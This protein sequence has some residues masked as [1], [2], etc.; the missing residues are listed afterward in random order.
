MPVIGRKRIIYYSVVFGALVAWFGWRALH[1][2]AI[3]IR[4][5]RTGEVEVNG[6]ATDPAR[7]ADVLRALDA[8]APRK[9]VTLAADDDV[10]AAVLVQA[11]EAAKAAGVAD[12]QFDR[13]P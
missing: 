12:V 4:V 10:T 2:D 3:V 13:Q 6:A 9:T 11:I 8:S 5:H 7:L 1:P